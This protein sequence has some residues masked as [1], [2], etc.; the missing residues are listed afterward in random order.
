MSEY[1]K[2][3]SAN[4][5]SPWK[6]IHHQQQQQKMSR[7][8]LKSRSFMMRSKNWSKNLHTCIWRLILFFLLIEEMM[9]M[10]S[11]RSQQT[12]TKR[13]RSDTQ[14]FFVS[15][16]WSFVLVSYFSFLWVHVHTV[17][18]LI[19]VILMAKCKITVLLG[20]W[21]TF[22]H[23]T[24]ACYQFQGRFDV[25]FHSMYVNLFNVI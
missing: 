4:Q 11:D 25:F 1:K 17:L 9:H 16:H 8:N 19:I 2:T 3:P 6:N 21:V 20:S 15:P 18:A 10:S 12:K 7:S 14:Q 13:R 5:K 22:K 23:E 24:I